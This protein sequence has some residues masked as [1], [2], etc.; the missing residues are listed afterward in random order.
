MNPEP[1]ESVLRS[2]AQKG[3]A[4][5]RKSMALVREAVGMTAGPVG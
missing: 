3:R 5:A 2:G 1:V 4:E